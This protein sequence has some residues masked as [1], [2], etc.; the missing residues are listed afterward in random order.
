MDAPYFVGMGCTLGAFALAMAYYR[1]PTSPRL[2]HLSG[3]GMVVFAVAALVF[4]AIPL[5]GAFGMGWGR[6]FGVLAGVAILLLSLFWPAIEARVGYAHPS[7][8]PSSALPEEKPARANFTGI[9]FGEDQ[10]MAL[11]VFG[12]N[13]QSR[14]VEAMRQGADIVPIGGVEPM[15][16]RVYLANGRLNADAN[17]ID[18]E[19]GAQ[20]SVRGGKV[21]IDGPGTIDYNYS[22]NALEVV[23]S[24]Q[25]PVFQMIQK[26]E[27][28]LDVYGVYAINGGRG[29]F[30]IADEHGVEIARELRP[31]AL[32]RVFR[33]PAWKYPGEYAP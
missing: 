27:S 12:G 26:H 15:P 33:Y 8:T 28:T 6:G 4:F 9:G 7:S 10:K 31:L 19:T 23:D 32:T 18:P 30:F 3:L 21:S 2:R 5:L 20:I 17:M 29:G 22:D 25:R 13:T 16:L 1:Y 24:H 11:L 14:P